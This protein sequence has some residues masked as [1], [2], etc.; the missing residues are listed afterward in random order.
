MCN[1]SDSSHLGQ[2]PET[3]SQFLQN[4]ANLYCNDAMGSQMFHICSDHPHVPPWVFRFDEVEDV[5]GLLLH[6]FP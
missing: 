4:T 3:T 5:F 2:S 6:I 1:E